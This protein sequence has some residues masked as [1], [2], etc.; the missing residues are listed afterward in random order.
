MQHMVLHCNKLGLGLREGV[1]GY[2]TYLKIQ[3]LCSRGQ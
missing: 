2:S 3:C 1:E